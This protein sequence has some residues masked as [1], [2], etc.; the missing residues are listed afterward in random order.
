M[1]TFSFI[2]LLFFFC[3]HF[4]VTNRN[5]EAN[6]NS[7]W[8][9]YKNYFYFIY[10][11][12]NFV[13][14]KMQSRSRVGFQTHTHTYSVSCIEYRI[15]SMLSRDLH[16]HFEWTIKL[17]Y[18]KWNGE[19]GCHSFPSVPLFSHSLLSRFIRTFALINTLIEN[20]M[21]ELDV[22]VSIV[23]IGTFYFPH[24][25]FVIENKKKRKR[26]QQVNRNGHLSNERKG[27]SV[28][29]KKEKQN[30]KCKRHH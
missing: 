1:H 15:V 4:V 12:A 13:S 24:S 19:F 18:F 6:D 2:F 21:S 17:L 11:I 8:K 30:T 5:I 28:A 10:K 26:Q 29:F 23:Q 25:G 14:F 9:P 22:K 7:S 20:N 3:L 16:T 27:A